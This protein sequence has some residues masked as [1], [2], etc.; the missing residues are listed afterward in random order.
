MILILF[1][2][3]HFGHLQIF[4]DMEE[5][6]VRPTVHIVTMIGDV[7]QKLDLLDKYQKLKKKYPPPR[8]EYRYVK[9]K[10]IKIRTDVNKLNNYGGVVAN[11]P[12]IE[13]YSESDENSEACADTLDDNT[14]ACEDKLDENTEILPDE[15]DLIS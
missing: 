2:V 8:W 4:A 7:F 6:G 5:L 14:E 11:E 3:S 12:D 15:V 1:N 10:R 9:G 13:T